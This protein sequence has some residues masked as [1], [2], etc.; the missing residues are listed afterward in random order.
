MLAAMGR[1]IVFVGNVPKCA[2]FFR[3][4]FDL[5]M[6][7]SDDPDGWQELDALA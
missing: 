4:A 3:D 7:P 1:V 2:T 5:Q 6:I